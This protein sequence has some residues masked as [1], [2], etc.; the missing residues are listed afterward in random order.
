MSKIIIKSFV[1]R[2]KEDKDGQ[3]QTDQ[4][5]YRMSFFIMIIELKLGRLLAY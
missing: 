1:L 2:N 4:F 5:N 3:F